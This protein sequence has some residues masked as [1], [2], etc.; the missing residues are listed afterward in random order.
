[1]RCLIRDLT[2]QKSAEEARRRHEGQL[3][4]SAANDA[5]W[6][7]LRAKSNRSSAGGRNDS[8]RMTDGE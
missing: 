2:Q 4:A 3:L 1:L 8:T 5:I 6:A 7:T